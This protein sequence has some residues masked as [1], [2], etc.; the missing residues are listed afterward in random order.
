[1]PPHVTQPTALIP[2]AWDHRA[3]LVAYA[4]RVLGDVSPSA[5]DVVQEAYLRLTERAAAGDAPRESRPWLFRVVRNLALDERRR[6]ALAP[7][8]ERPAEQAAEGT[9]PAEVL[10]RRDAA[11][12]TLREVAALP[13]RER[14]A[15]VLE[16][17]G[18]GASEIAHELHTT[19]N[20]VHQALFRA[21]RRLRTA[22]AAAWGVMPLPLVRLALRMG[23]ARVPEVVVAAGGPDGGRLL[24][25]AGV[26]GA[27][28]A[29]L[30][31]GGAAI[32][33]LSHEPVTISAERTGMLPE[34]SRQAAAAVPVTRTAAA[35]VR[36]VAA[37]ATVGSGAGAATTDSA[38]PG[39]GTAPVMPDDGDDERAR[40]DAPDRD[41]AGAR[42]DD[43]REPDGED[44][45]E[46]DAAPEDRSDG[47]SRDGGSERERSGERDDRERGGGDDGE[48]V[49]ELREEAPR[50]VSAAP[51]A[52]P[53][54]PV[55]APDP[56]TET[57]DRSGPGDGA[58]AP[59][60][61]APQP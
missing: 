2:D 24:P 23:E 3:D 33:Q 44:R 14:R 40:A 10:E 55:E 22:R 7:V 9:G 17:A 57:S 53:T 11:R 12:R 41:D 28:V 42:D 15:V 43:A 5:E 25:V 27:T 18:L 31:G 13:P 34:P 35:P 46:R 48:E 6:A 26:L 47:D 60:E 56:E 20:A 4:R 36:T 8:A 21:R 39:R 1:M 51:P 61:P 32:Q 50:P 29:G 30:I 54:E 49:R 38:G 45:A 52:V 59:Q 16:Q 37:R 19:P 58:T